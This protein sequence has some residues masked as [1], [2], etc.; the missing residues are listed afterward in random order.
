V[1]A[2]DLMASVPLSQERPRL[3]AKDSP[4]VVLISLCI[5]LKELGFFKGFKK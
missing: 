2:A 4:N 3:E 5:S 1:V